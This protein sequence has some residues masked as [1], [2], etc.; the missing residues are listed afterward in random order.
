MPMPAELRFVH[1]DHDPVT[2]SGRDLMVAAGAAVGL[3]RL[4]GL[5]VSNFFLISACRVIACFVTGIVVG[6]RG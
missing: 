6:H 1:G 5:N 3:D 2:G 4:V